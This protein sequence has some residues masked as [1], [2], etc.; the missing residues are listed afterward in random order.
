[1]ARTV[2]VGLDGATFSVLDPLMDA[3][4]MP[5]LASMIKS[6]VRGD[7]MSTIPPV[8]PT[9]W[10]SIATGR[11]PGNHGVFDFIRSSERADDVYFTL[12]NSRDIHGETIWTIA[13]RRGFRV[14]V[15]NYMLTFPPPD[16]DGHLIP[17]LVSWRHLRR[18]T[19]PASLFDVLQSMIGPGWKEMAWD[20]DL[21]KSVLR[22]IGDDERERWVALHRRRERHWFDVV[23]H[24]MTSD[25]SDLTAIVFD[26]VDKV[27]HACWPLL[28]P[29]YSPHRQSAAERRVRELCIEYFHDI[30][31]YLA[32]IAR[33]AGPD[34]RIFV[35]SDHG[36]GPTKEIFRV[37][38]W[39][40]EHGYL[41]WATLPGDGDEASNPSVARRLDSN[42]ALAD[43]Q[44]T[45]AYARTPSSNGIALRCLGSDGTFEQEAYE[46]LRDEV[47]TG[48]MQVM[49]P[50]TGRPVIRR[51]VNREDAFAGA[52]MDSAPD[53]YLELADDG[54]VSIRNVEP[55]V[56]ERPDVTGTHRPN[57]VIVAV[58]PGI[59]R[60][61]HVADLS[62]LDV[63]PLVLHSLGTTIPADMDGCL[64]NAVFDG[65]WL[66]RNPPVVADHDPATSA[67][68]LDDPSGDLDEPD[69]EGVLRR[70]ADLGYVELD[71]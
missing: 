8:S 19:R 64:P 11:Q 30:D 2:L 32:E 13:S 38:V 66:A 54:F 69:D 15:L 22:G 10:T 14:T 25:P 27:Q 70:L 50:L 67:A 17:G 36:F 46:A 7:L 55:V 41:E 49:S 20:F 63:A 26:G 62:V 42:F 33:A 65:R 1:M 18:G 16:I 47:A 37:N 61:Q 23:K 53:L 6:G 58:G 31:D 21:E 5:F 3:G 40:H 9:A 60:G 39:L 43:W 48:L 28:D 68:W 35:V 45:V 4:E 44:R 71:D 24:L 12:Y 29:D 34:A 57:G 59:A 52:L 51:V 56:G